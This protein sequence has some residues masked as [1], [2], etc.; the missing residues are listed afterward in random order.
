MIPQ[1]LNGVEYIC[2]F[3]V[4]FKVRMNIDFGR[5]GVSARVG[6]SSSSLRTIGRYDGE[7]VAD[8]LVSIHTINRFSCPFEFYQ[9]TR[10]TLAVVNISMNYSLDAVLT[11][12]CGKQSNNSA[13]VIGE[14]TS[15][16]EPRTAVLGV[17]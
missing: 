9:K 11:S 17:Q 8:T 2:V 5:Y 7:R 10:I 15:L 3:S 12:V 14:V 4:R 6:N 16:A 1:K 13:A